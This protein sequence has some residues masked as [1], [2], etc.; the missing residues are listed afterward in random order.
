MCRL[1]KRSLIT[2]ALFCRVKDYQLYLF[3]NQGDQFPVVLA[4]TP[5][6]HPPPC[7]WVTNL[8]DCGWRVGKVSNYSGGPT[9]SRFFF[10]SC[11]G[12][13]LLTPRFV[14]D[15]EFDIAIFFS[16]LYIHGFLAWLGQVE[17][18]Y[19]VHHSDLGPTTQA[20]L[21]FS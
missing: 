11:P 2:G 3:S 4:D 14:I 21:L 17:T 13:P 5:S 12:R 10:H 8:L 16:C 9:R 7:L 18:L 1:F 19:V 6:L 15:M 20:L